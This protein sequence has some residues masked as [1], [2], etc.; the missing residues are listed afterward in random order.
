[1]ESGHNF[2]G[3]NQWDKS[4]HDFTDEWK[5]TIEDSKAVGMR[6]L[7]SPGVD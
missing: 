2:L 1:M 5:K 7:I 4:T 6:Y 3:A